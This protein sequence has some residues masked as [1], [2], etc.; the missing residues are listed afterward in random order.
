MTTTTAGGGTATSVDESSITDNSMTSIGTDT[1][2]ATDRSSVM[3]NS[4]IDTVGE[5]TGTET[6]SS[7]RETPTAGI[8]PDS[9]GGFQLLGCYSSD[10]GF[11]GF[12]LSLESADMTLDLCAETC[13]DS[14]LF[15]T[16]DTQCFCGINNN[17]IFPV[18]ID[19]CDIECPGDDSQ[20]CGGDVT[21]NRFGR[22]RKRQNIPNS[23]LLSIYAAIGGSQSVTVTGPGATVTGPGATVTGPGATVTGSGVAITGPGAT[24]TDITTVTT[25][26]V[27]TATQPSGMTITTVTDVVVCSGGRCQP[28]TT[29]PSG[30]S[31]VFRPYP[32]E[33]CL[34]ELVYLPSH[35]SCPGG[36]EYVPYYCEKSSCSGKTVYKPEEQLDGHSGLVYYPTGCIESQCET[37]GKFFAPYDGKNN[38]GY[39][40]GDQKRPGKLSA[41]K[42]SPYYSHPESM[43][44][45][46]PTSMPAGQQ[47]SIPSDQASDSKD[48]SQD[49]GQGSHISDGKIPE[50]GGT[51]PSDGNHPGSGP[52][53]HVIVSQ[54]NK[55]SAL[56][57]V[58]VFF[59]PVVLGALV[60]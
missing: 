15:G 36:I 26:F 11:P 45:S 56:S 35:C 53:E 25:T 18:D 51:L 23:F 8:N 49:E 38:G 31:Y 5:M 13:Q 60:A 57:R 54:A 20:F 37:T 22:L 3:D 16:H 44:A 9:V 55:Q 4:V 42:Q 41:G 52:E 50:G 39:G 12:T 46:H 7:S 19:E 10:E 29:K 59:L 43:P 6:P 2:T 32:G 47:F 17:G 28:V 48:G 24:V 33:D 40:N 30:P 1:A 34:D 58:V 14:N 21:P 27:S